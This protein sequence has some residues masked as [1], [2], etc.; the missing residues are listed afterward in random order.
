MTIVTSRIRAL[1]AMFVL[2]LVASL[3]LT[4][5]KA[6]AD[7]DLPDT[8]NYVQLSPVYAG[9]SYTLKSLLGYVPDSYTQ[10]DGLD[11]G[12]VIV[13][14]NGDPLLKV[15]TQD[16]DNTLYWNVDHEGVTYYIGLPTYDIW[17]NK[18]IRSANGKFYVKDWYKD[19]LIFR[20]YNGQR[21]GP[22]RKVGPVLPGA[23]KV[24]RAK[25]VRIA[26]YTA[27]VQFRGQSIRV[28][29]GTFTIRRH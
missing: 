8:T 20:W 16:E 11:E 6:Q 9:G 19:P 1:L 18:R 27:E 28:D 12:T 7:D 25:N 26:N 10:P 2:A 14:N 4:P 21:P 24:V 15:G 5:F 29:F 22:Y 13:D 23:T 17:L 3:V